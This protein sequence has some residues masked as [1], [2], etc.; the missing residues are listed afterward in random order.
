MSVQLEITRLQTARNQIRDKAVELGIAPTTAKL[1]TLATAISGIDNK[2]AIT[3]TV[4][5][6][7]TYT[8]P[9]GYH[10][11]SGTVS[12]VIGGGS[13]ELQSKSI[14]PTKSQQSITPDAGYYGLS[15]VTVAA[16]PEAYQ[17]VSSVTANSEDVLTGKVIVVADGTVKAG[18]MTN[19][20]AVN[21]QLSTATT[22]YT[23][24]K[25]Y[26]NGLGKVS[27][28]TEAKSATPT[29]TAQNITPTEGKVL[30]SV[31]VAAIPDNFIDTTDA[32][33]AAGDILSGKTAYINGEAVEGTMQ[34]N[35]SISATIDGLTTLSYSIPVGFTTG[36]TISLTDD[37]ENAL[38]EI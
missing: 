1:E 18:T 14:T 6:G 26:H 27:I 3:A 13:Y 31:T 23:I 37:I 22:S 24:P 11:G 19:N 21:K 25:G 12:G 36:V 9:K 29:K 2:G 16:I 28:T 5:E 4:K 32:T 8:I 20:G 17:N 33:A 10:N 35:G 30:S 38:A 34:N 15:D 7:E